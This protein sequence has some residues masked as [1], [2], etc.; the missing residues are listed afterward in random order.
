MRCRPSMYGCVAAVCMDL[1]L[2]H[3]VYLSMDAISIAQ[4][5]VIYAL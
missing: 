4:K 1:A 5:R 2:F 3:K